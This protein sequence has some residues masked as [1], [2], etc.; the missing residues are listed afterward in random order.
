MKLDAIKTESKEVFVT[1]NGVIVTVNTWSNVEGCNLMVHGESK[2]M[3]IRMAGA[4][5]WEEIDV[6]LT[7][8]N[9]ARSV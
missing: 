9:A 7:A 4:F 8:L 5:R 1:G 6:I 3:P 2:E